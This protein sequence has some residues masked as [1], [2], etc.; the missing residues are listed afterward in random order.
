MQI[1]NPFYFLWKALS[2]VVASSSSYSSPLTIVF[3]FFSILSRKKMSELKIRPYPTFIIKNEKLLDVTAVIKK[4]PTT[5]T[6]IWLHLVHGKF[7]KNR[8]KIEFPWSRGSATIS[9]ENSKP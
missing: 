2:R 6:A 1:S 8:E 9:M 5:S 7:S 3:T 4:S